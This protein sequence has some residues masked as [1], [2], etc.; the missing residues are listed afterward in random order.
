[1][2][3][4]EWW[5]VPTLIGSRALFYGRE[6]MGLIRDDDTGVRQ[7]PG[8]HFLLGRDPRCDFVVDDRFVSTEHALLRWRDSEWWLRDLGSRNGTYLDDQRLPA[9]GQVRVQ[10][11]SE[12]R[13]GQTRIT[14]EDDAGPAPIA[15]DVETLAP[16]AGRDQLLVLPAEERPLATVHASASHTWVLETATASELVQDQQQIEVD[17]SRFQLALPRQAVRTLHQ[18]DDW[19]TFPAPSV[20]AMTFAVSRD[21]EHV[22]LELRPEGAQPYTVPTRSHHYLLLTLARRWLADRAD[23][24]SAGA[25]GWLYVDELLRLLRIDESHLNVQIYRARRQLGRSG[26]SGAAGLVER[27]IGTRQIR[28][29]MDEVEITRI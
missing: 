22:E 18:T 12:I 13:V 9:G 3:I 8:A 28:L 24:M 2:Q 21:E 6:A 25:R 15:W 23:G 17:G 11:R 14:I 16:I 26:V 10:S 5:A 7:S 29:G 4:G 27:R 1:M 20:L 19:E